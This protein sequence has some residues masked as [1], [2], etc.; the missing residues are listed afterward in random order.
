M[1]PDYGWKDFRLVRI[2]SLVMLDQKGSAKPSALPVLKLVLS[3][4][5]KNKSARLK[6][7]F[8]IQNERC[9]NRLN[10]SYSRNPGSSNRLS[11]GLMI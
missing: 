1:E 8:G 4:Q 6:K 2:S 11:E 9:L 5:Y 7:K 3:F 10:E